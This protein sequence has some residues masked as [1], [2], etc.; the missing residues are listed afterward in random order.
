M[1]NPLMRFFLGLTL[2]VM[3]MT[4][5]CAASVLVTEVMYHPRSYEDYFEYL[6]L[7]NTGDVPVSLYSWAVGGAKISKS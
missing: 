3:V 5:S 4:A 2:L 1:K 6:E 7:F